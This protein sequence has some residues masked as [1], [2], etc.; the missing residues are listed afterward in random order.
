M[1]RPV[2]IN[3][4]AYALT[5]LV[6]S[7]ARFLLLIYSIYLLLTTEAGEKATQYRSVFAARVVFFVLAFVRTLLITWPPLGSIHKVV[8]YL[9]AQLVRGEKRD[10]AAMC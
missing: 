2:L 8:A 3:I 4:S 5:N 7:E 10:T 6:N 9:G 1:N